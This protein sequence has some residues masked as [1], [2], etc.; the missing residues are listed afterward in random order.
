M[1]RA[2][3][4]CHGYCPLFPLFPRQHPGLLHSPALFIPLPPPV[5]PATLVCTVESYWLLAV[6]RATTLRPAA[7]P[8]PS[9]G[10]PFFFSA[11]AHPRPA[12]VPIPRCSC[13]PFFRG[14]RFSSTICSFHLPSARALA[15]SELPGHAYRGLI[16]RDFLRIYRRPRAGLEPAG[17]RRDPLDGSRR[18]HLGTV[19]L[20]YDR[21]TRGGEYCISKRKRRLIRRRPGLGY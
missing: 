12:L 20:S 19:S 21:R 9:A 13:S 1:H 6:V 5:T 3:H 4:P 10:L 17:R 2:I 14:L 16:G 8:R 11:P 18:R 15:A 7:T